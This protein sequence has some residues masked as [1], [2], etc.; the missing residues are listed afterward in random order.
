MQH[1]ADA[2]RIVLHLNHHQS[3]SPVKIH[4]SSWDKEVVCEGKVTFDFQNLNTLTF[5]LSGSPLKGCRDI[6]F[7]IMGQ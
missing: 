2:W 5:S 4:T 3:V 1:I 7:T 6:S